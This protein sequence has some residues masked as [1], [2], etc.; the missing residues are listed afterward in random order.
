MTGRE[1]QPPPPLP[2]NIFQ[3]FLGD[4]RVLPDQTE[5]LIPSVSSES[6]LGCPPSGMYQ[7]KVQE[8]VS[9]MDLNIIPDSVDFI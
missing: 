7:E 9:K 1:T 3:P 6:A 8:E 2:S 4:P 5:Y